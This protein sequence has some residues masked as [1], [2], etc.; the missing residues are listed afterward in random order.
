MK[1]FPLNCGLIFQGPVCLE[2][3]VEQPFSTP[4]TSEEAKGVGQ[5]NYLYLLLNCL[6]SLWHYPTF[7]SAGKLMSEQKTQSELNWRKKGGKEI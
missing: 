7:P 5:N 3:I 2:E 1:I 4:G 6:N